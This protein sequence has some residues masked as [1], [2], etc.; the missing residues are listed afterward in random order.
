MLNI[1]KL[2]NL[3]EN[4]KYIIIRF[5]L[6]VL[7]IVINL[8]FLIIVTNFDLTNIVENY[9][10]KGIF[11]LIVT[12]FFSIG[13]YLTSEKYNLEKK[14]KCLYQIIPII[15]GILFFSFFDNNP[16]D[17]ENIIFFIL[18]LV[19]IIGYIFFA[20]FLK[21]CT[22]LKNENEVYYPYFYKISIVFLISFIFGGVLFALGSIAIG[23]TF[24]LFDISWT[25][26]DELYKNWAIISLSL[27]TPIFG[28]TQIPKTEEKVELKQNKFFDFLIK[29]IGISFIIIYFLI[30]YAYSIKVLLNF[31]DWPKGEVSWLV[32]GFSSLG[33]IVYMFSYIFE[34]TNSIIKKF[35][36]I[37]PI[38]VIPQLFMLFYAIYLRIA[39][40]DLTTNR[41]FVVVFGIW[42][43]VIS[44]FMIFSKKKFIG[45][46]PAILT[47]FTIII[48]IGP[49]SVFSLPEARQFTRLENNLI[50]ANILKDGEIISLKD[51]TDIDKNLSRE[52]YNGIYYICYNSDCTSIKELFYKQLEN[53][54]DINKWE[55]IEK[56]TSNI[57][58][59]TY[60][61]YE[62][63]KSANIYL[64]NGDGNTF[65]IDTKG[66]S[67][68]TN[69]SD[70]II[71]DNI[72]YAKIDILTN[73]FELIENSI[74]VESI[75]I[76]EF[77]DNLYEKYKETSNSNMDKQD[78]TFELKG[79]KYEMKIFLENINIINPEY[80]GEKDYI[81]T[82]VNG[83]VLIK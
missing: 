50:K 58:V 64:N 80:D 22:L 38:V 49:W 54:D 79:Q 30:L 45:A 72:I 8:L 70:N 7:Y 69:I 18:S 43:G 41:Y 47:L 73:K 3:I 52:I 55:I 13:V 12:F 33:Y 82:Y 9:F 36:E 32:I 11:S 10:T 31:S 20:P 57:K 29:Y 51:F 25:F 44:L 24:T 81:N 65:P 77:L 28:L 66:Y 42:L 34:E 1:F 68:I 61:D 56:I 78:M 74:V 63:E 6:G 27:L 40:Y 75:D 39:Q 48:S 71:E 26:S 53:K 67:K 46:I 76:K 59:R 14:K 83:Y 2:E 37:F 16:D 21:K 23:A 35:R 5:P 15:F 17:F 19:G 60:Y 4:I 62:N